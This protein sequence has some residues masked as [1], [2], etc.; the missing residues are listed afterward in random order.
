MISLVRKYYFFKEQQ[1]QE[2]QQEENIISSKNNKNFFQ[3]M[4]KRIEHLLRSTDHLLSIVP[5][6]KF[7]SPDHIAIITLDVKSLY[8]SIR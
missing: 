1:E 3:P 7:A 2:E 8:A 6:L 4:L 5:T